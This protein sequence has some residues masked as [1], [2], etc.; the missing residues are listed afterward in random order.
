MIFSDTS[1]AFA[2]PEIQLGVFPP[3]ASVLLPFK[4]NES[5]SR[6]IIITGEKVPAEDAIRLGIVDTVVERGQLDDVV[7]AFIQEHILPKSAS[8]IR[9]ANEAAMTAI[10]AFY[11]ENIGRVEKL[12]LEKLMSTED[13]VNGIQ[14][15]LDK[16]PPRWKDA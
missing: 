1:A 16:K 3:P 6:R 13:A 5:T 7:T 2:V 14:A 15:F 4:C 11:R 12:Y 10:S 8:S 9:I